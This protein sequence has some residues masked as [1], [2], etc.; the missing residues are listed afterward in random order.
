MTLIIVSWPLARSL[1]VTR[2]P[3]SEG[4]EYIEVR[5]EGGP[6]LFW[7]LVPEPEEVTR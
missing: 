6:M 3:P 5:V 4:E 2:T 7:V 1:G